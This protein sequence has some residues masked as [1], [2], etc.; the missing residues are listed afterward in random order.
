MEGL[1]GIK[2]W[3]QGKSAMQ[4]PKQM[5]KFEKHWWLSPVLG[6]RDYEVR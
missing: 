3:I 6:S 5:E 2:W 1:L 4:A